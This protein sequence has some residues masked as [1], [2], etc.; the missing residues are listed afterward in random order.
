VGFSILFLSYFLFFLSVLSNL[1]SLSSHPYSHPLHSSSF[2]TKICYLPSQLLFQP[3][4]IH[5]LPLLSPL[6]PILPQCVTRLPLP[7]TRSPPADQPTIPT[8]NNPNP[9]QTLTQA[10]YTT[11]IQIQKNTNKGHETI[12]PPYCFPHSPT[13]LPTS[14]F[15]ATITNSPNFYS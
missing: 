3:L 9:L 8:F 2:C 1:P 14:S 15:N 11:T 12:S 6:P 13:S 5:S 7:P 4:L 10:P